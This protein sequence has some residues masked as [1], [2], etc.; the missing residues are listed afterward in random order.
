MARRLLAGIIL[1]FCLLAQGI[2]LAAQPPEPRQPNWAELSLE[3]KRILS[4][5]GDQWDSMPAI[6]RKRLLGVAKSYPKMKPDEQQRVQ[7]RLKTWTSL[8][9]DE[10]T[11]AR[12]K[13]EKLKQLP[14]EKRLEIQKKWQEYQQLPEEKKAQL[15]RG[16]KAPTPMA[17]PL[18][19]QTPKAN[20]E[21]AT[22]DAP[23]P[24]TQ[25]PTADTTKPFV[26]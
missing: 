15:R 8:T 5:V 4:P 25:N 6:Q 1:T 11:Q 18:A 7:K 14:P 22:S 23:A 3:Q 13:Y 16:K 17:A 2:A 19:I 21:P 9:P 26:N 20:L 24:A 12:N 10:R